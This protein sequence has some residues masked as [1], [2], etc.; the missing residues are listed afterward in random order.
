MTE[1]EKTEENINNSE[2]TVSE[3]PDKEN[4]GKDPLAEMKEKLEAAEKELKEEKD[5]FLRFYAD[6]DNYKKR[7]AREM[8]DFRKFAN[9]SLIKELLPVL[10]NLERAIHSSSSGEEADKS[11]LEGVDMT[12][13]EIMKILERFNVKPVQALGSPFD[14]NF[15]EAIGQEES[16][17]HEDNTVLKE[18][19]KGYMLHDRLIRPSMVLVSRRK[20]P[21]ENREA[22][23]KDSKEN[24]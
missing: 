23:E 21:V 12:L 11:I 17:E 10:D 16:D 1:K 24:E 7:S 19:Q 6:F 15:H 5:R 9:E 3:I 18:F 22:E 2:D 8:D 20:T 13:K 4:G 14:P